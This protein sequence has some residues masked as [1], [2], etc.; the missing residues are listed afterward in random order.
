MVLLLWITFTASGFR[1]PLTPIIV[2]DEN[3]GAAIRQLLFSSAGL[4]SLA[5]LFLTR[6]LETVLTMNRKMLSLSLLV[7]ASVIWSTN[8]ALTA[9]RSILFLFCLITLYTIT[10]SSRKPVQQL[11]Q[12]IV[13]STAFI[14]FISIAIHFAFGQAYTVNPV[15]PGLAGISPHPNT[16]APILSIGFILSLGLTYQ[17][18]RSMLMGRIAQAFLAIG[19]V[20]TASMTTLMATFV[21]CGLFVILES[22][23]YR[24]GSIHLLIISIFTLCSLIGWSNIKSGIFQATGKDDSLSGRDELWAAIIREGSKRPIFGNGF[25]AFW[26]EG[27]GRELVH[28]WN[29]RQSHNSYIDLW[30]DLGIFGC[31]IFFAAYLV[32]LWFR[33]LSIRGSPGSDQRRA[34]SALYAT[35]LSYLLIRGLG[36]SFFLALTGFP[37]MCL[38]W[39]ILVITN[40]DL[41]CIENEFAPDAEQLN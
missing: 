39:I 28:T 21:G 12:L 9:K 29:P 31:T 25:G 41:N 4:A 38:T 18:V 37:F 6:N 14:A 11:L 10:Y 17:S 26:T 27:K 33:W 19:H 5:L 23:R 16:L 3:S 35:M 8:P 7:P 24:R 36:E 2:S 20:L 22:S 15:R 34:I 40:P 30:L 1:N 13:T 32:P